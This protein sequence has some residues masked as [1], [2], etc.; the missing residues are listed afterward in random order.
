VH[1]KK[2]EKNRPSTPAC[3][4]VWQSLLLHRLEGARRIVLLGIGQPLKGDDAAGVFVARSIA[5][6]PRIAKSEEIAVI[7]AA[8]TPESRTAEIRRFSPSHVLMI[9]AGSGGQVPGTIFFPEFREMEPEEITTHR[10]PLS[11]LA[12]YL[13]ETVPCKVILVAI[14][15]A[16]FSSGR[17][18]SP[19]VRRT[20]G[21]LARFLAD[22]LPG[23]IGNES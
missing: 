18:L 9:D 14:E 15:P 6:H 3:E 10:L 23:L 8:D 7:V 2:G 1:R 16:S 21:Q 11:L 5:R 4:P 19:P 22:L 20:A 13:E 17:K 12:R